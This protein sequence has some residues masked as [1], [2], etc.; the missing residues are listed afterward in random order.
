MSDNQFEGTA[1]NVGGKVESAF[2]NVTGDTK[3]KVEGKADQVAGQAQK[4]FGDAKDA[5]SDAAD[6]ASSKLNDVA[7]K[8][9]STLN[10]VADK[11]SSKLGGVADKVSEQASNIGGQVYEAG[12]YAAET[13]ADY[14]RNE[15]VAVM[16][17]VAAVG[18]L[19]GYLIGRPSERSVELGRFRAAYRDR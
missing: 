16:L 13:V 5:A 17:G 14:V 12:E 19:I 18:M 2:G 9:G 15:P 6:K 7:N 4:A 1:R 10:D 8:A 11:A 3:S